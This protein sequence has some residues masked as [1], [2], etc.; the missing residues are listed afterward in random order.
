[1]KRISLLSILLFL[2]TIVSPVSKIAPSYAQG[3]TTGHDA[4]LAQIPALTNFEAQAQTTFVGEVD[5]SYAYIAFVIQNNLVVIYVCDSIGVYPWIRAEVVNGVINATDESGKVKVVANVTAE[6]V[7]GTVALPTDDDGSDIVSYPFKTAPAVP[8]KTGLARYATED[9]ISGW[10]VTEHGTR[11]ISKLI[12]CSGF[13][14]KVA[15]LRNLMSI[16]S[17]AQ[18]NN[19]IANDI[20]NTSLDAT[21]A[22]CGAI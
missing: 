19:Q 12:T 7:T 21:I 5:G 2:I 15:T 14:R 10:I 3:G 18:V 17:D 11:G 6:S 4:I 20:I 13:K 1:M 16:N 9:T 8:G 22:G